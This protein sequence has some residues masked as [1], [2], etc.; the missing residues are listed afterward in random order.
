VPGILISSEGDPKDEKLL[1]DHMGRRPQE[2]A[3]E[4]GSAASRVRSDEAI[5]LGSL[6]HI[7][8]DVL[9]NDSCPQLIIVFVSV[10][11]LVTILWVW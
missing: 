11:V 10:V 3:N 1:V 4:M 2:F 7:C 5:A 6:V 8:C 9:V